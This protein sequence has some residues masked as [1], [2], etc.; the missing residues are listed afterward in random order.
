MTQPMTIQNTGDLLGF[1]AKQAE[2]RKD[3]FGF[4]QQRMTAVTLAHEIARHHAPQM[5]PDEVVEY[6]LALNSAIYNKIIKA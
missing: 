5:T 3:W 1:L 6:A 4:S 2:S